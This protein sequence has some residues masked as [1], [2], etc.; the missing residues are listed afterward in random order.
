MWAAPRIG[1][2]RR[3]PPR[4]SST[5]RRWARRIRRRRY[6]CVY[7][8]GARRGRGGGSRPRSPR[9]RRAWPAARRR[10][11]LPSASGTARALRQPVQ[12]DG[13]LHLDDVLQLADEPGI[14]GAG[15]EICFS[16]KPR[17]S[18]CATL[19]SRSGEGVPSAPRITFLSSPGRAPRNCVV[20]AG[21]PVS[22]ERSA[23]CSD[24]GKVR[25]MAMPRPPIS[26]RW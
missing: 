4:R 25:P 14:D 1:A 8:P 2:A 24:S 13:L 22:I 12:A 26:S 7:R 16:S 21:Q 23:F 19:S 11:P 18:A 15:L 20:E 6:R 10:S 9:A 3:S 17:R 5:Y